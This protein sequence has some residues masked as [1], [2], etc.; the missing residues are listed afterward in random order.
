MMPH[1]G[2]LHLVVPTCIVVRD[3]K[4]L[5][6]KRGGHEKAYPGKWTVPGGKLDRSEYEATPKT[7]TDAWYDIVETTVRREVL[8]ETG[9]EIGTPKYVCS[10]AFIRPDDLAVVTLSYWATSAAGEV[11]ISEDFDEFA[12]VSPAKAASYDMIPGIPEEIAQVGK[13][14]TSK[15]AE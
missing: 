12:W 1:P 3:G 11:T 15:R 4:V 13:L 10:L 6:L 2:Q 9:L 8:E 5:I 7:T 14:L